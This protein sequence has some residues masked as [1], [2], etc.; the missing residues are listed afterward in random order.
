MPAIPA[1]TDAGPMTV[2]AAALSPYR[3]T[4]RSNA[5]TAQAYPQAAIPAISSRKRSA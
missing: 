1:R 2:R 5:T 4:P 3:A